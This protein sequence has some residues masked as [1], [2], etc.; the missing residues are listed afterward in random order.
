MVTGD[1]NDVP[2]YSNYVPQYRVGC[3]LMSRNI[4]SDPL[5]CPL[6]FKSTDSGPKPRNW[7]E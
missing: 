4:V 6:G 5:P 7:L 3:N 2:Y 1:V